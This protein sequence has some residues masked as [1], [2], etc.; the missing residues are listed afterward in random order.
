MM[1]LNTLLSYL[2]PLTFLVVL[3]SCSILKKCNT[4]SK[5]VVLRNGYWMT[6]FVIG[7]ILTYVSM[8]LQLS[9]VLLKL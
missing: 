8:C 2:C 1:D 5:S 3:L 9:D 7:I 6:G 4:R